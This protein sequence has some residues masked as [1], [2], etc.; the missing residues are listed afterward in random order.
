MTSAAFA[1]R[2]YDVKNLGRTPELLAHPVYGSTVERYVNEGSEICSA[3]TNR[4][5]NLVGRI[6][7]KAESSI[8]TYA[9]DLAMIVAVELAQLKLLEEHFGVSLAKAQMAFGYSLGEVSA[10]VACGVYS[11]EAALTP[12][13][14]LAADAASLAKNVRMGIVFSRGPALNLDAVR[15]LCLQISNEGKGVIG[16]SSHLSPN[17]VLLLGQGETVVEFKRRMGD[18]LPAPVHLRENPNRWPPMHTQIVRQ[19]NIPNRASVFL[20]GAPGGFVV[21]HPPVLSMVTGGFDYNDYNSREMLERWVD[22]PQRVW[23]VISRTLSEGVET[24]IHLGP[25]PNIL[26]ATFNRLS[27]DVTT[28]LSGRSLGSLGLRAVSR[29][30]RRRRPWLSNL[31]SENASLLRAPFVEQVIVEDWLLQQEFSGVTKVE[32]SKSRKV[33][34]SKS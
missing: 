28:Q 20:D 33:E 16:I 10:L 30:V 1:F 13:L 22:H 6:R 32:E 9:Q 23:S 12:L 26:P 7:R 19:K 14:K 27:I 8:H 11:M 15:R 24:V 29:I 31:L 18:V 4:S 17:T 5:I 25:D 3:A 21:P 34:K 2:G